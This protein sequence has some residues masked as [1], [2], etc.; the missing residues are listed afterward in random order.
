MLEPDF[1]SIRLD[2]NIPLL[3]FLRVIGKIFLTSHKKYFLEDTLRNN[4]TFGS[5]RTFIKL[6]RICLINLIPKGIETPLSDS[7]QM[8]S[9]GQ[10]Q[11]IGIALYGDILILDEATSGIVE[12]EENIYENI[13][14]SNFKTII[15]IL[16][17]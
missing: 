5:R 13:F 2:N 10:K 3:M 15:C 9:G 12:L 14:N 4:I 8:V 17:S 16:T 1:G 7:N 6:L 11:C